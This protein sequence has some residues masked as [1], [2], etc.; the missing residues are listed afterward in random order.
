VGGTY[1]MDSSSH[2]GPSSVEGKREVVERS[3]LL[4][5]VVDSRGSRPSREVVG[6]LEGLVE[7]RW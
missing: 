1:A 3:L 6:M 2:R 7:G 5:E 4:L